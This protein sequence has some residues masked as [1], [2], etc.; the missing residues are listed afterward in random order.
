MYILK[1]FEY[2]WKT[3]VYNIRFI[4]QILNQAGQVATDLPVNPQSF[5]SPWYRTTGVNYI[6][7]LSVATTGHI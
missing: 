7:D 3:W 1:N 5:L 2:R 6:S 4:A